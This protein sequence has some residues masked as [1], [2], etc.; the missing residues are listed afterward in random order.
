MLVRHS[1]PAPRAPV[2]D[3][4]RLDLGI[5]AKVAPNSRHHWNESVRDYLD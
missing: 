5:E 2:A 4:V 3:P 1:L